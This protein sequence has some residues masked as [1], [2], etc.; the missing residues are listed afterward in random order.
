M[1]TI[2]SYLHAYLLTPTII[3]SAIA[4]HF[5]NYILMSGTSCLVFFALVAFTSLLH[6]LLQPI[7]M[8]LNVTKTHD[9]CPSLSAATTTSIAFLK[10]SLNRGS[11]HAFI[12]QF[13]RLLFHFIIFPYWLMVLLQP[14][15]KAELLKNMHIISYLA[16]PLNSF[17]GPL[18][19]L[20]SMLYTS[21]LFI[22]LTGLESYHNYKL[23]QKKPFP[24]QKRLWFLKRKQPRCTTSIAAVL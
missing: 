7:L 5:L 21:S 3:S 4:L 22:F 24:H 16:T 13:S 11:H 23:A 12:R 9:F 18:A 14:R 20:S 1:I 19:Q 10:Y 8:A 2:K 17:L 15:L 6:L